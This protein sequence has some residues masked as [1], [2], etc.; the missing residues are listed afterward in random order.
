M[1]KIILKTKSDVISQRMFRIKWRK[2][3][4]NPKRL[5]AFSGSDQSCSA[6][7]HRISNVW[8]WL[9]PSQSSCLL[10]VDSVSRWPLTHSVGSASSAQALVGNTRCLLERWRICV[11]DT[12]ESLAGRKM[13]AYNRT[14]QIIKWRFTDPWGFLM[15]FECGGSS[16]C[17]R[18]WGWV[19]AD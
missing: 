2:K 13:L 11:G 5:K 17:G 3:P 18:C 16:Q 8:S 14:L 9:K 10:G 4:K 6:I 15:G 19:S 12:M 1:K 7:C